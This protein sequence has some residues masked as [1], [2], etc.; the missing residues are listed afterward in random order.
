[1][2]FCGVR[3]GNL[4]ADTNKMVK[5]EKKVFG[6][7]VGLTVGHTKTRKNKAVQKGECLKN[8]P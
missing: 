6:L 8:E 2:P 1:M 7:T 3:K 4:F 5:T